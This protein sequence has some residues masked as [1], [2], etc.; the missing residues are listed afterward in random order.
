MIPNAIRQVLAVDYP[1]VQG[2]QTTA[3]PKLA[4]QRLSKPAYEAVPT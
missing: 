1:Y 2:T 4:C 3:L